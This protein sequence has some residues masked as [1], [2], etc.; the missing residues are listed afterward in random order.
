MYERIIMRTLHQHAPMAADLNHA[1]Y[2]FCAKQIKQ[3][4]TRRHTQKNDKILIN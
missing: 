3:K 2:A 1:K 4:F